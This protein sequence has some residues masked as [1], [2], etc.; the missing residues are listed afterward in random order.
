MQKYENFCRSLNNLLEIERYNAPYSTVELTGIVALYEICF[1]QAW[2]AMK[3]TLDFCGFPESKTG[4]PK[5]IL[6]TA[7]SADMISDEALWLSALAARN[8][9]VHAYNEA[10]A[11]Q[12]AQDA[13]QKYL[14][15][16]LALKAKLEETHKAE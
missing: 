14:P 13:K 1:E 2:K 12:I 9:A 5:Q 6:K 10:I 11:Q 4:S 3:E 8:N 15:M 7:Y 16:F